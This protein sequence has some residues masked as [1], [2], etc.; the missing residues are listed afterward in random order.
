MPTYGYSCSKCGVEF[1][2]FQPMKDSAIEVC[3]KD[4]CA[5]KPWGRGKVKRLI[6][7]GAG[8][9]FKGSGFYITDYRS[10]GYKKDAKQDSA[11]G[12]PAPAADSKTPAASSGT[13]TAATESKA[14]SVSK[15]APAASKS[16]DAKK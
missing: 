8:L 14:A 5:R 7:G 11:P 3:P 15:P 10:E 12:T 4:R 13:K 2:Y 6:S 9:I 16:T 1:D